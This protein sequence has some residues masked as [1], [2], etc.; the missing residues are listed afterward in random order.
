MKRTLL[1]VTACSVLCLAL[2]RAAHAVQA[3][4]CDPDLVRLRKDGDQGYQR[5]VGGATSVDRC[6]GTFTPEVDDDNLWLAGFYET[7]DDFPQDSVV[8]L[9]VT[10]PS[11]S[12]DETYITVHSVKREEPFRMDTEVPAGRSSFDWSTGV[13][14]PLGLTRTDLTPMAF[15][16]S[17]RA[18]LFLPLRIGQGEPEESSAYTAVIV[19]TSRLSDVRVSLARVDAVGSM[20]E[21]DAYLYYDSSLGSDDLYITREPITID[22]E[23]P[24]QPGIYEVEVQGVRSSGAPLQKLVFWFYHPAT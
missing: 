24:S 6:E 18:A 12:S 22:I 11:T 14:A 23:K 17:D 1:L 13:V 21:A 3:I 2:P 19:P 7:F 10:W 8:G 5:R 4:E 20:P 9:D 15:T 16:F